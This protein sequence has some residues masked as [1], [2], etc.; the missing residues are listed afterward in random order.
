MPIAHL[1]KIGLGSRCRKEKQWQQPPIVIV[2]V[3]N[4]NLRDASLSRILK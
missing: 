2:T 1:K 3:G 4:P